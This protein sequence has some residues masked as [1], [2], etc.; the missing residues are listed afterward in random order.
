[1]LPALDYREVRFRSYPYTNLAQKLTPALG[2]LDTL[3]TLN[4][5]PEGHS[6]YPKHITWE[7]ICAF[8]VCSAF[9]LIFIFLKYRLQ[10]VFCER[11]ARNVKFRIIVSCLGKD[12]LTLG[13]AFSQR[14]QVCRG[15]IMCFTFQLLSVG[16][17]FDGLQPVW[18]SQSTTVWF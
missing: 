6:L 17:R 8:F 15:W 12:I 3:W 16:G 7:N 11:K 10:C 13:S 4:W 9:T 1:M 2:S 5:Y 14:R 18:L